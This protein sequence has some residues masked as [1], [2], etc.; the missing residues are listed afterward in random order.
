MAHDA[1]SLVL[2]A[3]LT[4]LFTFSTSGFAFTDEPVEPETPTAIPEPESEPAEPLSPPSNPEPAT[5]EPAPKAKNSSGI[6]IEHGD[7]AVS[8]VLATGPDT[9][10][11][12][13]V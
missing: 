1:M 11:P 2:V 12:I 13:S 4:I 7:P 9:E 6:E 8:Q 3:L 10:N 5:S